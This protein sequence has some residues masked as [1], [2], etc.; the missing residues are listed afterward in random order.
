MSTGGQVCRFTGRVFKTSAIAV[1]LDFD[2]PRQV[3]VIQTFPDE[4][5]LSM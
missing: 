2:C 1:L 4:G 5:D 3:K